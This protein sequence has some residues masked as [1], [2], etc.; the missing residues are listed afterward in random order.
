MNKFNVLLTCK[1]F[2]KDA[3][4][5]SQPIADLENINKLYVFR[6]QEAAD[7]PNIEY[8]TPPVK[9]PAVI[10]FMYRISQML[11]LR[12]KK[13]RLIIG[14]YEIPHGL[15]AV[16]V[17]LLRRKPSVLCIIGNPA[18][19]PVRSGLRKKVT[20]L[21]INKASFVTTTGTSSKSF[22][23]NEGVPE[24]K[25]FI[26]P[27]S[28]DI[29][30]FQPNS[31]EK[32]FDIISIGRLSPEKRI[33][34]FIEIVNIIRKTIPGIKV[35]IGGDGPQRTEIENRIADLNLHDTITMKG[36][37]KDEELVEFYNKSKLFLLCS[38]TEGFPRTVIEAMACG[39]P[40]ISTNV[41]DVSDLIQ[42]NITG[43][44]VHNIS[45]LKSFA[46]KSIHLL[47]DKAYYDQISSN[48]LQLVSLKCSHLAAQETWNSILKT[49]G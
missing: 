13:I 49:I 17:G 24:Y 42:D 1:L 25:I 15:I 36:Y 34:D 8:I 44:L 45:D 9:K 33:L 39:I 3:F 4:R 11:L 28:I 20:D 2:D 46:D 14:I 19:T 26:L 7:Y 30:Y 48:A 43:G 38:E 41:G 35:A 10:K 5:F 6:D 18:Y 16:L 31:L 37:I 23:V 40:C 22:L 47:N 29:A 32:E 27:N 21:I 12:V